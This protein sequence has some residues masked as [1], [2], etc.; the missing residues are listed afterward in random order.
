MEFFGFFKAFKLT[1]KHWECGFTCALGDMNN[2][3]LYTS[4]KS[5]SIIAITRP[6]LSFSLAF[7]RAVTDF[8]ARII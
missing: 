1:L 5:F 6:S 3:S 4:G 7:L 8:S 2:E